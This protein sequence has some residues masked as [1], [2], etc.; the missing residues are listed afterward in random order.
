MFRVFRANKL[1]LFASRCTAR[2]FTDCWQNSCSFP[3]LRPLSFDLAR[4]ATEGASCQGVDKF[5][6]KVIFA[7]SLSSSSSSLSSPFNSSLPFSSLSSPHPKHFPPP[8]LTTDLTLLPL[9]VALTPQTTILYPLCKIKTLKCTATKIN[10]MYYSSSCRKKK[11]R[12]KKYWT[13]ESKMLTNGH[14]ARVHEARVMSLPRGTMEDV[15]EKFVSVIRMPCPR[16]ASI[17][18]CFFALGNL[19]HWF[20]IAAP[21]VKQHPRSVDKDKRLD[22]DVP[23]TTP[24]HASWIPALTGHHVRWKFTPTCKL[25]GGWVLLHKGFT[26]VRDM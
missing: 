14:S 23:G 5:Q 2:R 20:I 9:F 15:K 19:W 3:R 11:K 16:P 17:A 7:E 21:G 1:L 13:A 24:T 12:L 18:W 22:L 10:K 8:S 4:A 6:W 25:V 26:Q